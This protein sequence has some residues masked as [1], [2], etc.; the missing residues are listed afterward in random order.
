MKRK[1]NE[2]GNATS[3]RPKGS[4]TQ[5]TVEQV[6]VDAVQGSTVALRHC[7]DG[8]S[9]PEG[10]DG[11]NDAVRQSAE[12]AA[13]VA[14]AKAFCHEM[15]LALT[16]EK[17]ALV[18]ERNSAE[19]SAGVCHTHDFCDA[20]M[21]MLAAF[22]TCGLAKDEASAI[23]DEMHPL[24]CAAWELAAEAE[25]RA[26]AVQ[27]IDSKLA[28]ANS[29]PV[30]VACSVRAVHLGEGEGSPSDAAKPTQVRKTVI[31]FTVLHDDG[32]DLSS[33]SLGDIVYECDDGGY[34]GGALLVVSSEALTHEQL[35][36]E[37]TRLGSDAAF[38]VVDSIE[39]PPAPR[40]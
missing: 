20:N 38:F 5:M 34:V 1:K 19:T 30:E 35:D 39:E 36:V 15:A 29:S 25:F 26:E 12:T 13:R 6:R 28:Q 21:L 32:K 40:M 22:V 4:S 7:A 18:R 14:L 16:E 11:P 8:A 17:L 33:R 23:G 9:P 2:K 10:W 27:E 31:Q 37:A 24:W 3:L